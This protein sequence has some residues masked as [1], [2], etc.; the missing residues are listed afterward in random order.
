MSTPTT[1]CA[2]CLW[3]GRSE[4]PGQHNRVLCGDRQRAEAAANPRPPSRSSSVAEIAARA[5]SKAAAPT[6]P[7]PTVA[8]SRAAIARA[9]QC[10]HRGDPQ[11]CGC[12]RGHAPCALNRGSFRGG[13]VAS[14]GDCIVCLTTPESEP[15]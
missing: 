11:T 3:P 4:C 8:E 6:R 12:Q 9:E 7:R 13:R 10:P 1:R 2:S 14:L 15:C 5:A